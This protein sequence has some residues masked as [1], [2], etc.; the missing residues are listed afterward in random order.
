MT[1]KDRRNISRSNNRGEAVVNTMLR[2]TTRKSGSTPIA[3]S[4]L[5]RKRPTRLKYPS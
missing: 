1:S 3:P 5:A 4:S 2:S